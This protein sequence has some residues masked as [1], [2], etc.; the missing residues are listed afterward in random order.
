M[1]SAESGVPVDNKRRLSLSLKKLMDNERSSFT[2]AETIE[3]ALKGVMPTN[4]KKATEYAVLGKLKETRL[5]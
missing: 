5:T 2:T 1:K 4:T 3:E